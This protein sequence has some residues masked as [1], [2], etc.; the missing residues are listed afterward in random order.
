[1]K[2]NATISASEFDEHYEMALV[3]CFD[4]AKNYCFSLT[5]FP[6]SEEIEIMVLD[7]VN[8]RV[9]DLSVVLK[10]N[11]IEVSLIEE[12][13][14]NLDGNAS[15]SIAFDPSDMDINELGK[16]LEKIFEGKNGFTNES[17]I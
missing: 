15:Y 13:S 9:D 3:Y 7:Q 16:A 8:H 2:L 1:M 5:R 11:S 4:K 6:D 17:T 12:T 14:K 10:S